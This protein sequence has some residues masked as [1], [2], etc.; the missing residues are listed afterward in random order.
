MVVNERGS[1]FMSAETWEPAV[2][3]FS[4][5][6]AGLAKYAWI[7]LPLVGI[8]LIG[9]LIWLIKKVKSKNSQW[10]HTLRVRRV[11]DNNRLSNSVIH[12]MRRFP[13][14]KK[15]EVFELE[16]PLLGCYLLPELDEYSDLNEYSII[17]DKNNR[18]YTNKGEF[19]NKDKS[20][21]NVSAKHSEIDIQRQNLKSAFQEINKINKRIEW[22]TIAKWA[23]MILAIVCF[24]V[25]AIIGI[26]KWGEAQ[27]HKSQAEQAKAQAFISLGEAMDTIQATVNTQKLEI[28]P[29]LQELY[30]TK[31]IR[32]IINSEPII[33]PEPQNVST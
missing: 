11:L 8:F 33:E 13:L 20:S 30:G 23:F 24:T 12:R 31:N 16:K 2:G 10:T 32:S 27:I 19:F 21:V 5:G 17:L 22:A 15:A 1:Y 18:I 6:L 26:S 9:G 4:G 29:M 28:L 3:V 25:L 7:F 14:I